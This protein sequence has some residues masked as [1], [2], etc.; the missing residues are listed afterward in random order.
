MQLSHKGYTKLRSKGFRA[1]PY[2]DENGNLYVGYGHKLCPDDGVAD[3]DIINSFKASELLIR[4]VEK[5][6]AKVLPTVP[7]NITQDEFDALVIGTLN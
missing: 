2:R 1:K 4:D 3:K 5:A 6:V 7:S